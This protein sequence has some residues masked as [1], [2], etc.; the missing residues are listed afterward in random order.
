MSKLDKYSTNLLILIIAIF[1]LI[2][3][4]YLIDLGFPKISTLIKFIVLPIILVVLLL[5]KLKKKY[6]F[7]LIPYF[8]ITVVYVLL[9][10]F[11]V[12]NIYPSL[13]LTPNFKY[14]LSQELIYLVTLILPMLYLIVFSHLNLKK[15]H[16]KLIVIINSLLT[17]I[18]IFLGNLFT[19]SKS[20]YSGYTKANIFFW[21]T[22]NFNERSRHPRFYASKFFFKEG[23]TIGILMLMNLIFLYLILFK[24]KTKLSKFLLS[25]LIIIHSVAMIMLSTRIATYGAL[26]I[27]VVFLLS[28]FILLLFKKEKFQG[29]F[30]AMTVIMIIINAYLIP[31]SPAYQNQKIDAS[32]YGIM[33]KT[34]KY[35]DSISDGLKAGEKLIPGSAEYLAFYSFYFED[36]LF[37]INITPPVY[38]T[39]YYDYRHDPKFWV[40]FIF[41]YE[42]EERVSGRQLQKIFMDYKAQNSSTYTKLLGMGYSSFMNGSILLEKDFMQQKY[43]LGIIGTIL[44]MGFWIVAI[45]YLGFRILFNHCYWKLENFGLM[46]IGLICLA[47]AYI[48]GH[49]LDQFNTSMFLALI[50]GYLYDKEFRL[51]N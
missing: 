50:L 30:L 27:P 36:N 37:L 1:P 26:I 39:K 9:H 20:T 28:Y 18:P 29:L 38:Y 47:S 12:V 49:T 51:S 43:T 25:F 2:E 15:A 34:L 33:K 13:N 46:L 23:N 40:D 14:S 42:L 11:N 19:F 5:L 45:I 16:L 22:N 10:H 41:N 21:F 31:Y 6:L 17:A 8:L 48:S 3:L 35:R 32:D 7:F 4:D 44:T 24:A